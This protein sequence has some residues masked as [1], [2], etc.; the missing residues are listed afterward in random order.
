MVELIRSRTRSIGGTL[1]LDGITASLAAGALAAAVLFELVI[2]TTEGSA[3]TVIT[4]L[5]YPLG[6]VLLLSA[7]FGAFS[8]TGWRSGW[9]WTRGCSTRA[10]SVA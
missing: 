7:V 9:R 6:D 8:L 4:N 3:A 1:W 5:A 2:V 10:G